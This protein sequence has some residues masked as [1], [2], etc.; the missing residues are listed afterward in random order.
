MFPSEDQ[1]GATSTQLQTKLAIFMGGRAAEELIFNEITTGAHNDIQQATR[2]ARAMVTEYGMSEELGPINFG[3]EGEVFVGKD[4]SKV[5]NH[6][7]ETSQAIDKEVHS[8][9]TTAYNKAISILRSNIDILHKVATI[10]L[11]KETLDKDEF[12]TISMNVSAT[13]INLGKA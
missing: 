11:E 9:I 2:I 7:E 5:R 10:L 12:E 1:L 8:L 13:P 3:G 6:S 4:Y